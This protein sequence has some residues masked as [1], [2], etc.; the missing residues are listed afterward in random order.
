MACIIG[1]RTMP[2]F[3]AAITVRDGDGVDSI[4]EVHNV[5]ADQA[6]ALT[7]LQTLAQ[8]IDDVILGKVVS[9]KLSQNVDVSGWSLKATAAAT[10]DRE[11]KA[12]FIFGT[13]NPKVKPKLSLPTFDKDSYTIPGGSI[14]F[15]LA[16]SAPI[17]VLLVALV[18][19]GWTD[20]RFLD[21]GD[22]LQAYEVFE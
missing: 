21:F 22:V 14:P 13:A 8:L 2:D 18:D 10:A 5:A 20:Y 9:A 15:D 19:Q 3:D 16:G 17:D 12:R 4:I 11:I 6:T 1:V 7:R